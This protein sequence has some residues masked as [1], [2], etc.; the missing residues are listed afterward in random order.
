MRCGRA[1]SRPSTPAFLVAITPTA[2]VTKHT[3]L[4]VLRRGLNPLEHGTVALPPDAPPQMRNAGRL[5]TG[6]AEVEARWIRKTLQRGV[7][8]ELAFSS[9]GPVPGSR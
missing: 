8:H 4:A 3:Y 7:D 6:L 1:R 9:P 2:F 5:W